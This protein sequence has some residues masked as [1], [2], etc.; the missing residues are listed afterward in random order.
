[1]ADSIE[2]GILEGAGDDTALYMSLYFFIQKLAAAIGVGAA[3][4]IAA[5]L[6]FNPQEIGADTTFGGIKFVAAVLPSII[7]LPAVFLLFNYPIDEKRHAEIRQE[8][9]ERGIR[10]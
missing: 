5:M 9:L 8:L 3:L 1:V 10:T 4:P 2:H 7:A 6:G